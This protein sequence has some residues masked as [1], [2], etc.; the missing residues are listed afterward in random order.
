MQKKF[1]ESEGCLIHGGKK[2]HKGT[3]LSSYLQIHG[4]L[5]LW[6]GVFD[7]FYGHSYVEIIFMVPYDT[8]VAHRLSEKLS[9]AKHLGTSQLLQTSF[10]CTDFEIRKLTSQR[11]KNTGAKF[12]SQSDK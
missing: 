7:L 11:L 1:N 4:G 8:I 3:E 6:E 10:K 5:S 12:W 2:R 9:F